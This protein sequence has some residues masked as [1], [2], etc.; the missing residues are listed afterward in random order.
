[1]TNELQYANEIDSV[2]SQTFILFSRIKGLKKRVEDK[3]MILY[4]FVLF[5]TSQIALE[6]MGVMGI[7][8]FVRVSEGKVRVNTTSLGK[9]QN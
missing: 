5:K 1:M 4:L 3:W 6:S 7:D 8:C 2:P 9:C